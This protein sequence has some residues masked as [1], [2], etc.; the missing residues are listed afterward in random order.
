MLHALSDSGV[1]NRMDYN[2]SKHSYFLPC[3]GRV[4]AGK[5]NVPGI[6]LASDN[7]LN[8]CDLILELIRFA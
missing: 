4:R 7:G 6:T 8:N 1:H 3:L 5:N 2:K